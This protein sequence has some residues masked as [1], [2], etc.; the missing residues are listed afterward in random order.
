MLDA[1]DELRLDD[2]SD[3]GSSDADPAR[4]STPPASSVVTSGVLDLA[5]AGC[6]SGSLPVA[7]NTITRPTAAMSSVSAG[8]AVP[9]VST[10]MSTRAWPPAS[11][12]SLPAES[13]MHESGDTA[14]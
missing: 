6:G 1:A 11:S 12:L 8:R 10:S 13:T 14:P 7:M 2:S 5:G 9:L 3:T 4:A